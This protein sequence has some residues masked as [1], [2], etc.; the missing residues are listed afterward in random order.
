M[1]T[2]STTLT[3]PQHTRPATSNRVAAWM[4]AGMLDWPGRV[5]ATLFLTGCQL[6]CPYCHNG[7]LIA[8]QDNH[9]E[10]ESFIAY[11]ERRR[12]WI[13]G[14]VITG[15]EPTTDPN[16]ERLLE[17]FAALGLPVK[18]DT[19]GMRPDLLGKFLKRGLLSYVAL[20][21][22]TLPERYAILTALPDAEERIR[23]SIMTLK[24]SSVDHEF[25]TT[26]YP[27]LVPLDHLPRIAELLQGGNLYALQQFRS[28]ATL[29]A[30]ASRREPHH[31]AQLTIVA[32][33]CSQMIPTITRGV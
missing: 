3:S 21:V 33:Q 23:A 9:G 12:A 24:K 20:D 13:D 1:T 31:P 6:R 14:V 8:P 30:E 4:P 10:W 11:L 26:C 28:G 17:A 5:A 2:P 15:G 16:I 22:K 32:A 27:G 18:L 29:H 7:T 25:R 19:N